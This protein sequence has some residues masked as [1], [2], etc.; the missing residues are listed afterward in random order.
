TSTIISNTMSLDLALTAME[1]EKRGE[2]I[3][4]PHVITTDGQEAVIEQGQQV[5]YV[6]PG[7]ANTPATTDFKDVVLNLTVT[8]HITPDEHVLMDMKLTQDN[9]NSFLQN[10]EPLIDT[11]SVKTQ[12]LVDDGNTVV[13]GGIFQHE[14]RDTGTKIPL[15]GDIPLIGAL[16]S[17]RIRDQKKL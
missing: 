16:F 4:S 17:S 5:P 14:Q 13:L 8:P 7:A 2:I 1:S 10:G 6:T 12:V 15:L 11:R 9:V 3:S